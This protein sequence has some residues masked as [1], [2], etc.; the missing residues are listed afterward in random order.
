MAAATRL[1]RGG[2]LSLHIFVLIFIF[3]RASTAASS[4]CMTSEIYLISK[5]ARPESIK[6]S[7]GFEV[8]QLQTCHLTDGIC[9]GND[10]SMV[11]DYICINRQ[12]FWP[13][14]PQFCPQWSMCKWRDANLTCDGTLQPSDTETINAVP[15]NIDRRIRHLHLSNFPRLYRIVE[16]VSNT[17]SNLES[18]TVTN[19]IL[20]LF[21]NGALI[22]M[23][24][25][26][27]LDFYNNNITYLEYDILPPFGKLRYF[28]LRNNS[29]HTPALDAYALHAVMG[30]C[31][32]T[33]PPHVLLMDDDACRIEVVNGCQRVVCKPGV[34]EPALVEQCDD[35][36]EYLAPQFCDGYADCADGSD[37][38]GCSGT[39]EVF[40]PEDDA[41][42]CS[43]AQDGLVPEI[44]FRAGTLFI[45]VQ[46]GST[47]KT[48]IRDVAGLL[49]QKSGNVASSEGGSGTITIEFVGNDM[50]FNF[51]ITHTGPSFELTCTG[52]YYPIDATT[53]T[54]PGN[55]IARSS[56]SAGVNGA[57]VGGAA[58]AA[59]A[60]LIVAVV[61]IVVLRQRC[62]RK[63]H[64]TSESLAME[65]RSG[66]F[67]FV[68]W[69][70]VGRC[71]AVGY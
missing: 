29:L 22:S 6:E 66:V 25:L 4:T 50:L 1:R 70:G 43:Y 71:G 27:Y 36:G 62:R 16:F 40:V 20:N 55:T 28:D 8:Q 14:S 53:T 56:S 46:P 37:E 67:C 23:S 18:L 54:R 63:T 32:P 59:V 58:G 12:W 42:L 2:L 30:T 69:R 47:L 38:R 49:F 34:R 41:G 7:C 13:A 11:K 5:S 60:V 61:A 3:S 51:L 68:F 52:R 26:T 57:A 31:D 44:T 24:R 9:T 35:G 15:L 33:E 39:M 48:L 19:A 64:A 45:H 10:D 65:V 21:D 17:L